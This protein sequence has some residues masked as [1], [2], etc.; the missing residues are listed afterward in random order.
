MERTCLLRLTLTLAELRILPY[1]GPEVAISICLDQACP[2]LFLVL[3]MFPLLVLIAELLLSGEDLQ[4]FN[5][6][7]LAI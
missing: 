5:V 6:A 2:Y 3:H 4:G 7:I 1:K